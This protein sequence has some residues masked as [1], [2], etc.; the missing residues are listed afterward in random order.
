ML[1]WLRF[2][3]QSVSGASSP[4]AIADWR[5][6]AANTDCGTMPQLLPRSIH[7]HQRTGLLRV[8]HHV[9]KLPVAAVRVGEFAGQFRQLALAGSGLYRF[10]SGER[11]HI[12][13]RGHQNNSSI[14]TDE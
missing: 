13:A 11:L 12:S 3:P 10:V 1:P 4:V 6:E 5:L 9:L 7:Q 14:T 8:L 2:Q